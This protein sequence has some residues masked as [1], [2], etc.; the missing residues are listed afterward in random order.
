[1]KIFNFDE[2]S[3]LN[4]G[5]QSDKLRDII[6]KHGFPKNYKYKK[7]LYDIKNSDI[8]GVVDKEEWNEHRNKLKGEKFYRIELEDGYFIVLNK[9]DHTISIWDDYDDED[10][11]DDFKSRRD[12]RHIG[13]EFNNGSHNVV[14]SAVKQF[15]DKKNKLLHNRCLDKFKNKLLENNIDIDKLIES[16]RDGVKKYIVDKLDDEDGDFK[17]YDFE[18]EEFDFTCYVSGNVYTKGTSWC[19]RICELSEVYIYDGSDEIDDEFD[20]KEFIDDKVQLKKLFE[21]IES[22]EFEVDY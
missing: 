21:D 10:L 17:D 11:M 2:Y 8:L 14:D 15:K 4:E 1:M 16:I 5:F 13:N 18:I 9:I 7:L 12:K 20:V 22:D 3:F 6:K 19:K